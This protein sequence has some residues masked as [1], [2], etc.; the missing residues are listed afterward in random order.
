MYPL[1]LLALAQFEVA[2]IRPHHGPPPINGRLTANA[3]RL[4][5]EG[6]SVLGLIIYAYDVKHYQVVAKLDH[7]FYDI[8]AIGPATADPRE[9]MRALLAER[10]KLRAR[11]ERREIPV[12]ALVVGTTHKLTE[13]SSGAAPSR[14]TVPAGPNF[15]TTQK[16][17]SATGIADYISANA[18]LDRPVVDRTGLAGRYDF[19]LTFTPEHRRARG[20]TPNLDEI[21]IFTAVQEQ[22]GLRLE[23]QTASINMVVVEHVEKPSEN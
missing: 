23:R 1:L 2:S 17:V 6:Y 19:R 3:G 14:Q 22:L 12:F 8:T 7:T 5:I 21:T 15:Q 10:F 4:T 20:A 18:G 11:V 16:S 9:G 13:N